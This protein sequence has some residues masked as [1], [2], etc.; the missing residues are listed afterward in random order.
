ML[1]KKCGSTRFGAEAAWWGAL[2][3]WCGSGYDGGMEAAWTDPT[4][5]ARW[6]H[7][8]EGG[9]GDSAVTLV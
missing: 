9:V 2:T 3:L 1:Q 5:C 4:V 6:Q 7:T 8:V